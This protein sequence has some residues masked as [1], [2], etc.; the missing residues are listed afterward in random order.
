MALGFVDAVPDNIVEQLNIGDFI[1]TQ[2]LNSFWSWG[3]MYY[4]S[5][6]VDHAA[7]YGGDGKVGHMTLAGGKLHS[8]RA[9][10]KGARVIIV[11]M[12]PFE[13]HKFS[14]ELE[15]QR[16]RID[17]GSKAR[18]RLPPKIQLVI[19]GL[20]IIHGKYPNR[21]RFKFFIEFFS[22]IIAISYTLY[23]FSGYITVFTPIILSLYYFM[24]FFVRNSFRYFR[25]YPS[26]TMS[27]PDLL[28]QAYFKA[29]GLIFTNLGPIVTN[30]LIGLLPLKV[31][32]SLARKRSDDGPDDDVEEARKFFRDLVEGWNLVDLA[33]GAE[34]KNS[35]EQNDKEIQESSDDP[36]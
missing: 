12:G 7:I 2:R 26:L 20:D 31:F 21:F 32:L 19:A 23:F 13:L 6:N 36:R 28:L 11:R 5:S 30:D 24:R 14:L 1:F 27:Y 25:K 29:G 35:N 8:L 17:T 15:A 22:S 3:L 34:N 16:K 4:A 18:H 9:V 10:A 33:Q